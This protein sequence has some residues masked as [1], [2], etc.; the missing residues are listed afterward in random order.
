MNLI[1]IFAIFGE[2]IRFAFHSIR[3]NLLRTTLSLMGVTMGVF[4]IIAILTFVDSISISIKDSFSR[5]GDNTIF[6]QKW[7]WIFE[8]EYPW[9]KYLSRPDAKYREMEMLHKRL[10]SADAIA[11]SLWIPNKKLTFE[12]NAAE[13]VTVHAIT[14]EYDRVNEIEILNGRYFIEEECQ[15]GDAVVIIG[16]GLARNIFKSPEMALDKKITLLGRKVRVIGLRNKVGS[17]FGMDRN[18]DMEAVVPVQF[19][20]SLGGFDG[21]QYNPTIVI[22]GKDKKSTDEIENDI[23]GIFRGIRKLNPR[24]EDNFALNKITMLN[25]V[26]TKVFDQISLYGWIIAAFSILVGGF[27]IA[28]IMFVSVKERTNIIGIQKALG[29]KNFFIMIQFMSESVILCLFGGAI[30][31]LLVYL[32]GL[33]VGMS[34]PFPI[35]LTLENILIGLGLSSLIGVISGFIPARQAA[36]LDPIEAIRTGI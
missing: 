2:S 29:A 18:A 6:V 22:R 32:L 12:N 27:G 8:N 1:A 30:A 5:L 4:C 3:A 10:S 24:Q 26:I 15:R 21:M 11:F 34:T 7:P 9:W 33:L 31:L 28:N 14:Y 20:R 23:R 25:T 16:Y 17:S 19:V 35:T 13:G 36:H